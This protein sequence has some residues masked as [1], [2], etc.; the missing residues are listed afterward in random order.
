MSGL[1]PE[2]ACR[3]TLQPIEKFGFDASII[4]SDILLVLSA[5]G[6]DLT[7]KEGKGPVLTPLLSFDEM[8]SAR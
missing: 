1:T 5:L 2:K 3:V 6:R 4:F 8:K 7:F